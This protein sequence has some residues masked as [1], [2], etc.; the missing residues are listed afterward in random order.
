[1]CHLGKGLP[2]FCSQRSH[3]TCHAW[4]LSAFLDTESHY[5][6]WREASVH[7]SWLYHTIEE[8]RRFGRIH[9]LRRSSLKANTFPNPALIAWMTPRCSC[10]WPPLMDVKRPSNSCHLNK[11]LYKSQTNSCPLYWSRKSKFKVQVNLKL[12]VTFFWEL[13]LKLSLP[14]HCPISSEVWVH[15]FWNSKVLPL[16]TNLKLLS[17]VHSIDVPLEN[18]HKQ[19]KIT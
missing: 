5:S 11:N 3:G 14:S 12:T 1:M 6:G 19:K 7:Q 2:F 17:P 16:Q 15:S 13:Q 18:P 8:T 10:W 9:P 4:T